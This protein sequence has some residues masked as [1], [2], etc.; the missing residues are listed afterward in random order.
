MKQLGRVKHCKFD[1][2]DGFMKFNKF[3]L[4]YNKINMYVGQNGSG[5]TVILK[6]T[7]AFTMIMNSIIITTKM[8][9]P[10][11][12]KG[13]KI[14][15]DGTFSDFDLTG[16]IHYEFECGSTLLMKFDKGE[17]IDTVPVYNIDIEPQT[18][19]IFMSTDTRLLNDTIKYLKTK[20]A[21]GI[22][23]TIDKFTE[24]DIKSILSIY[25]LYDVM[26]MEG[27][28]AK[29]PKMTPRDYHDLNV[30]LLKFDE[31]FDTITFMLIDNTKQDI[32]YTTTKVKDVSV[33]RL[34][35]GHQSLITMMLG[36][37]LYM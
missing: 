9:L 11:N 21:L 16:S 5:K 13:C 36:A 35:N 8:K 32:L 28:L 24:M 29:I 34:G 25:K 12:N 7:W 2:T 33:S 22:I 3:E 37:K 31:N 26:F 6:M 27:L 20:F 15:L 14:I 10:L 4:E 19:P 23:N 17:V 30:D 18:P 1:T